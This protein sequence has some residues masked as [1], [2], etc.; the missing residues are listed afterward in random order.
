MYERLNHLNIEV[1]KR[2]LDVVLLDDH[3]E[4]A[5][6]EHILVKLVISVV[7]FLRIVTVINSDLILLKI[8]LK[9][10][11]LILLIKIDD[12]ERVLKA[13]EKVAL[14]CRHR[15]FRVVFLVDNWV[16]SVVAAL[17]TAVNLLL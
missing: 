5:H 9:Y 7:F 1:L 15:F 6:Q 12:K 14:V 11:S 16:D 10:L 3:T 4:F 17:V 13:D 2:S 8:R